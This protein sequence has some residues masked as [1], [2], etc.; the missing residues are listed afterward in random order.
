[1]PEGRQ[2][3]R[4]RL[5]R[6]EGEALEKGRSSFGKSFLQECLASVDEADTEQFLC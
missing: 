5:K 4:G 1:M 3:L 6:S 2:A